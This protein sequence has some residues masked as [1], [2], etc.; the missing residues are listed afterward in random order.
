[1]TENVGYFSATVVLPNGDD[2]FQKRTVFPQPAIEMPWFMFTDVSKGCV[3]ITVH[4][5]GK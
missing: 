5:V 3:F 2:P 4:F 1:L